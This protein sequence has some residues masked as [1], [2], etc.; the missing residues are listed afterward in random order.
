MKG[1]PFSQNELKSGPFLVIC[2]HY[3][4][5]VG[6]MPVELISNGGDQ[7]GDLALL[8]INSQPEKNPLFGDYPTPPY[9]T[10]LVPSVRRD[11]VVVV[12]LVMKEDSGSS[13]PPSIFLRPPLTI[14]LTLFFELMLIW[15]GLYWYGEMGLGWW[16]W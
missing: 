9:Y 1:W 10:I 8:A 13:S 12:G 4:V 15:H 11:G 2:C 6:P 5:V 3:S 14:P 16:D 7:G